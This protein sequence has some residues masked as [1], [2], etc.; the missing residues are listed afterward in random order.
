MRVPVG[1]TA[2]K[3]REKKGS[4]PAISTAAARLAKPD[5]FPGDRAPNLT[6]AEFRR[7]LHY[8]PARNP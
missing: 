7:R 3:R 4:K 1:C 2:A 6:A 8:S 5:P